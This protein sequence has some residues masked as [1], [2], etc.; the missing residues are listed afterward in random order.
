MLATVAFYRCNRSHTVA[1]LHLFIVKNAGYEW[2]FNWSLEQIQQ[3]SWFGGGLFVC[4]FVFTQVYGF[5]M[6]VFPPSEGHMLSLKLL[7]RYC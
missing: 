5:F 7:C 2:L 1:H 6:A 3:I 4:L